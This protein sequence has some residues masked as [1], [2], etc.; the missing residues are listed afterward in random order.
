[1]VVRE[2]T[3]DH[4][5]YHRENMGAPAMQFEKMMLR[6]E[7]ADFGVCPICKKA[8][9]SFSNHYPIGGHNKAIHCKFNT[10]SNNVMDWPDVDA[11][12]QTWTT[13]SGNEL[14]WNHFT[15]EFGIVP[16]KPSIIP[17]GEY[18]PPPPD[19]PPKAAAREP[20]APPPPQ[21]SSS[22]AKTEKREPDAEPPPQPADAPTEP[23]RSASTGMRQ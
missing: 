13:P 2:P 20:P 11:V 16:I 7:V 23:S 21:K 14:F 22:K 18:V 10:A 3:L 6:M 17:G 9:T 12:Y 1:M 4:L 5:S 8:V 15:A 19:D